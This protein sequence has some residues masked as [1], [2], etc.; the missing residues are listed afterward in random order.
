MVFSLLAGG[1]WLVLLVGGLLAGGGVEGAVWV[2]CVPSHPVRA[3]ISRQIKT[4]NL[5][6]FIWVNYG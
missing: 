6:D 5:I 1:V 3:G 2:G 4:N